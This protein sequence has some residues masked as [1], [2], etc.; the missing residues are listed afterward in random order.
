MLSEAGLRE[1]LDRLE[2]Y[3]RT[4]AEIQPGEALRR[5][6]TRLVRVHP[7]RAADAVQLAAAIEAAGDRPD[8]LP[9]V[10][11]DRRLAEAASKEGFPIIG[12]EDD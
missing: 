5:V 3:Q 4:W 11:L 9:F 12:F 2:A 6:A 8:H 7:L 1:G 10:T